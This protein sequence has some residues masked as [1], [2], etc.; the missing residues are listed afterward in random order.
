MTNKQF[1]EILPEK[2]KKIIII[3]IMLCVFAL[4][5]SSST[6]HHYTHPNPAIM[7]SSFRMLVNNRCCT[8]WVH[9]THTH[10]AWMRFFVVFFICLRFLCLHGFFSSS[11][12]FSLFVAQS[13]IDETHLNIVSQICFIFSV[14]RDL[15]RWTKASARSLGQIFSFIRF[16]YS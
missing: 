3:S 14:F 15:K 9:N 4:P 1:W 2:E 10:F 5:L 8:L 16:F 12:S 13:H 6:S 7:Y 11:I